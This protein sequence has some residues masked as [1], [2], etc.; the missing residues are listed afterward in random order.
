VQGK[1]YLK[2]LPGNRDEQVSRHSDPDLAFHRV[3]RTT[4]EL[5]D[6]KMLFDP[7]EKQGSVE[8]QVG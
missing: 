4:E 3:L 7:F 1:W 6:S 8:F 5:V 2:P